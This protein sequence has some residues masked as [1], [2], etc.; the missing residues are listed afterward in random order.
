M[1]LVAWLE[2]VIRNCMRPMSPFENIEDSALLDMLA[3]YTRQLTE[4][5]MK[6]DLGK[7][8]DYCKHKIQELQAEIQS[9]KK[10]AEGKK[11]RR[12]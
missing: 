12:T 3:E 5:F 2:P 9:R 10:A 8:Y 4:L 1:I 7:Q 11:P 6:K